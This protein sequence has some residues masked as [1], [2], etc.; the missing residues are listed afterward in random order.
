LT[1]IVISAFVITQ[2]TDM[3]TIFAGTACFG[4]FMAPVFPTIF[5]LAG[6]TLHMTGQITGWF[7]VSA[8]LAAMICPWLV[9]LLFEA[10]GTVTIVTSVLILTLIM[11]ASYMA[12]HIRLETLPVSQSD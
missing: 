12:L 7:F 10:Y 11:V 8:G 9:G 5:N 2:A 6:A 3:I 4:L 1:G